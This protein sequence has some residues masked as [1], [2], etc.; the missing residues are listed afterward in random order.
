MRQL[1]QQIFIGLVDQSGGVDAAALTIEA[2]TG[3]GNK[4]TVSKMRKGQYAISVEAIVALEN[5]LRQ[6][7]FTRML[8]DRLS[9]KLVTSSDVFELA[10]RFAKAHGKVVTALF[11]TQAKA[12]IEPKNMTPDDQAKIIKELRET[13]TI[14]HRLLASVEAV[15]ND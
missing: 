10:A 12:S 13:L 5:G 9:P 8:Y 14:G 4:G 7:P 3:K 2:A 11:S 1:L 6:Y 15:G